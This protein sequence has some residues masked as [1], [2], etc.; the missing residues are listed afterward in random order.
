MSRAFQCDICKSLY[1]NKKNKDTDSYFNP[2]V[3]KL[4]NK[5]V[6]LYGFYGNITNFK[7]MDVY[8]DKM[9][10]LMM[11]YPTHQRLLINDT[12]RPLYGLIG[13]TPK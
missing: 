5:E 6:S 11:Q 4:R 7:M 9:S 10:E 12:A 2:K 1:C 8:D 13:T 3:F